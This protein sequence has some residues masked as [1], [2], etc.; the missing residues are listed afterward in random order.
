MATN[1]PK[2]YPYRYMISGHGRGKKTST[3]DAV[4]VRSKRMIAA[5]GW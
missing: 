3:Q 4:E 1:P 5:E 2:P